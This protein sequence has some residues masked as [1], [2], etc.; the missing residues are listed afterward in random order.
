MLV[1]A[2]PICI[3]F[4]VQWYLVQSTNQP[5]SPGTQVLANRILKHYFFRNVTV[6]FVINEGF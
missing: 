1:F 5:Q 2:Q 3:R 4:L 6:Y